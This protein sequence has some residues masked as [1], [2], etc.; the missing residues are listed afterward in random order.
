MKN[1]TGNTSS[2]VEASAGTKVPRK[3]IRRLTPRN[4]VGTQKMM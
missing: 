1:S 3:L 4:P 2:G